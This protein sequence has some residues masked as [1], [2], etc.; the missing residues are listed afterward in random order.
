MV[1]TKSN[2]LHTQTEESLFDL[3]KQWLL[4]SG[5]QSN[6]GGFYAWYDLDNRKYS[7]LYSEITGYGIS[8]LLFLYSICKDA[9]FIE[10]ARQAADWIISS[11]LYPCGGIKTRL[12]QNDNRADKTYSFSGQNIF[13][14]D[15]G[16]VLYGMINLY[17]VTG[18]ERFLDISNIL[19]HF[20]LDNMQNKDGSLSPIFNLN[21]GTGFGPLNSKWSNQSG[22]FHAKV[23]LGLVELFMVTKIRKYRNAAI[24]LCEYALSIQEDSGRFVT[25]SMSGTTNLH[26]HCYAAEGLLYTGTSFNIAS[27]IKSARK[28]TQWAFKHITSRGVNEL[29]DPSIGTFNQVQRSDVLAQVLRLGLIFSLDYK[30]DDLLSVLL[31]YQYLGEVASQK[32]GF[33]FNKDKQDANSWCSMFAIQALAF[34][35]DRALISKDLKV[36]LLI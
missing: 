28:A 6:G 14:F 21:A 30:I 19:A 1:S 25:N 33:L 29:Y 11:S 18:D 2:K 22:A 9:E 16:M 17:K 23:C 34:Y 3:A 31:E 8:T 24:K 5:I 20:L 7:Y 13:S 26:P 4:H 27:F 35:Q 15:T 12:Y 36:N 10:R 32:G